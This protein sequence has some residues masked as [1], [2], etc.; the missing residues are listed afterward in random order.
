MWKGQYET[1]TNVPAEALFRAIADINNWNEWGDELA[2]THFEGIFKQGS[3]FTLKPK[4]GPK[5]EIT[6]DEIE[7]YRLVYTASL[8][9]AKMRTSHQYIESSGQTTIRFTVEVWGILGFFWRKLYVEKRFE[10]AETQIAALVRSART[11]HRLED[12]VAVLI[13]D[14]EFWNDL[15]D[16]QVGYRIEEGGY[17]CA[18]I[19]FTLADPYVRR[20]FILS[21]IDTPIYPGVMS[22]DDWGQKHPDDPHLRFRKGMLI[23]IPGDLL[24]RCREYHSDAV[25]FGSGEVGVHWKTVN[26]TENIYRAF[27][28]METLHMS[29]IS[30]LRDVTEDLHGKIAIDIQSCFHTFGIDVTQ[31]KYFSGNPETDHGFLV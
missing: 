9:M 10:K 6:I 21:S 26:L 3:L 24:V 23:V 19:R 12:T 4:A 25:I 13:E 15:Y 28:N 17:V 1:T 7:P 31:E 22:T 16:V 27:S 18:R 8:F 11:S 30:L 20:G 2:F 14:V 29:S 5:I